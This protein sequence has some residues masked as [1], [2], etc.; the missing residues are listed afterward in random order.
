[1]T[2]VGDNVGVNS[3]DGKSFIYHDRTGSVSPLD[4]RRLMEP[5]LERREVMLTILDRLSS[6][7]LERFSSTESRGL[8]T[9]EGVVLDTAGF[10][11]SGND[12]CSVPGSNVVSALS[13]EGGLAKVILPGVTSSTESSLFRLK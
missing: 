11:V 2:Y 12:A 5:V 6:A 7:I 3:W 9:V 13:L 8:T 4:Q 1:M 10:S